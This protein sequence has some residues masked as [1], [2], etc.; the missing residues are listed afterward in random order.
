[1]KYTH[2]DEVENRSMEYAYDMLKQMPPYVTEYINWLSTNKTARTKEAYTRDLYFYFQYIKGTNKKFKTI[3]LQDIPLSYLDSL[4]SPDIDAY[5]A[6]A[7]STRRKK[8]KNKKEIILKNK[9]AAIKRKIVTL[10]SFLNYLCMRDLIKRNPA[11]ITKTPTVA[12]KEIVSLTD[13]EVNELLN[14]VENAPF[15]TV[16]QQN[17]HEKTKLRDKAIILLLLGTGIRVSELVGIDMNDLD[18]VNMQV[19]VHL[20]GNDDDVSLFGNEVKKA[21]QD[22]LD[23][24]DN[25]KPDPNDSH[26]LFI[27]LEHRRITEKSV[28]NMI[29]KYASFVNTVKH[30]TP[31][32]LRKTYGCNAYILTKDIFS[33]AVALHQK[34]VNTTKKHYVLKSELQQRKIASMPIDNRT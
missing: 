3:S 31:H 11:A 7:Q 6:Y 1:M 13:Q 34:D 33:V 16:R 30:I 29:S 26:A 12:A 25:L 4:K 5:S 19:K 14:A 10:R 8:T 18:M 17:A 15:K 27:S 23:V 20:K 21:I 22:Y 9:D 32:V 28:E 2:K 24:R